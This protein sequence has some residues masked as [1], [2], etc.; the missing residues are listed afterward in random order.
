MSK[1]IERLTKL[2]NGERQAM[3]FTNR[4]A[5]SLKAKIQVIAGLDAEDAGKLTGKIAG[6]DVLLLKISGAAKGAEIVRTMSSVSSDIIRG[7]WLLGDSGN[8]DIKPLTESGCDFIVFSAADAP[9][10]VG[11]K[12]KDTGKILAVESSLSEGLL[13]TL[14]GLAV[15]AVLVTGEKDKRTLT[16]EQLMIF[17]RFA[18]FLNKPLLVSVPS[19]VT[20]DE[21]ETLWESGINGVVIEVTQKLPEDRLTDLRKEIDSF[22]FPSRRSRGGGALVPRANQQPAR[23]HDDDDDEDE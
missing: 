20:I 6:A 9:M 11:K 13:R 17:R 21:L 18:D 22:E 3:G 12:F 10:T 8:A 5:A 16:V 19:E 4:Q 23:S 2:S 15:D 14:N 7:A 1:F